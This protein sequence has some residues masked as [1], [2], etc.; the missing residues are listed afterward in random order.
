MGG[1]TADCRH[2]SDITLTELECHLSFVSYI[3]LILYAGCIMYVSQVREML[4]GGSGA[5]EHE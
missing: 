4:A 5:S 3:N 2:V 1:Q